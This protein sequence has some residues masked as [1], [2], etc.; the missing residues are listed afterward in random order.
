MQQSKMIGNLQ[1]QINKME[2]HNHNLFQSLT[3]LKNEKT[4]C[5][6][7]IVALK[8]HETKNL[9]LQTQIQTLENEKIG[10]QDQFNT[11]SLDLQELKSLNRKF[12]DENATMKQTVENSNKEVN[13]LM[14]ERQNNETEKA[15]LKKQNDELGMEIDSSK[16]SNTDLEAALSDLKSDLMQQKALTNSLQTQLQKLQ[17]EKSSLETQLCSE[18]TEKDHLRKANEDL[19][20]EKFFLETQNVIQKEKEDLVKENWTLINLTGNLEQEIS[21]L[22]MQLTDAQSWRLNLTEL[23]KNK[24]DLEQTNFG[25]RQQ[26]QTLEA[27]IAIS[28]QG[29][30][31]AST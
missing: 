8:L 5:V 3:K 28:D 24:E 19:E 14:I 15:E 22:K 31:R 26:L 30:H 13:S 21:L 23:E 12:I 17:E 4:S 7:E 1:S 27:K 29:E 25:L 11:Q 2:Q 18:S 16:R 20:I 6:A 10:L 9:Y